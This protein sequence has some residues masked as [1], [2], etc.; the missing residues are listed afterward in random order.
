[1]RVHNILIAQ[2]A[3]F[4]NLL[5][6]LCLWGLRSLHVSSTP[7][8]QNEERRTYTNYDNRVGFAVLHDR[9]RCRLLNRRGFRPL[10]VSAFDE[11]TL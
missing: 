11:I 1:M 6:L 2:S 7:E 5:D 8:A 3:G 9:L 10:S 4:L